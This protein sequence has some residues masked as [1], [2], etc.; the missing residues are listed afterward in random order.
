MRE[1]LSVLQIAYVVSSEA[2]TQTLDLVGEARIRLTLP[3]CIRDVLTVA[4]GESSA[5]M[6]HTDI[7]PASVPTRNVFASAEL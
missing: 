2:L 1:P 4:L 3:L 5:L 7:S 6:S